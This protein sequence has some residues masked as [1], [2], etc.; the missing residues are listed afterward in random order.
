M[1]SVLFLTY[2]GVR[3]ATEDSKDTLIEKL[4][5]LALERG[6]TREGRLA[7]VNAHKAGRS[8]PPRKSS[9]PPRK[10][11]VRASTALPTVRRTSAVGNDGSDVETSDVEDTEELLTFSE[12]ERDL[13]EY[14]ATMTWWRSSTSRPCNRLLAR[15][16]PLIESS[17]LTDNGNALFWRSSLVLSIAPGLRLVYDQAISLVH[18]E[19]KQPQRLCQDVRHWSQS[20]MKLKNISASYATTHL[21]HPRLRCD[22]Q[23]RLASMT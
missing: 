17:S 2:Y 6:L 18:A 1:V 22:S 10:S 23:P 14:T 5:R 9:L 20:P 11:L 4:N 19:S 3:L 13:Q 16:R 21:T 12:E 15:N 7:I 8:L